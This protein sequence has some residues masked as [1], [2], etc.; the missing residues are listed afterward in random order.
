MLQEL[1]TY[2]QLCERYGKEII[3]PLDSFIYWQLQYKGNIHYLGKDYSFE[4][5]L[6]V[7]NKSASPRAG[8]DY[9]DDDY[10]FQQWYQHQAEIEYHNICEIE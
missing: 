3:D 1:H 8:Y 10:T 5:Y 9:E 7:V 2:E 4:E 6:E